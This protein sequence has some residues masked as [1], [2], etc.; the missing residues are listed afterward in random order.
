MGTRGIRVG[1]REIK[2]GMQGIRVGMRR[3]GVETLGMWGMRG[4]RVEMWGIREGMRGIRV[5]VR[6]I[7]VGMR[8]LGVGIRGIRVGMR[9]IEWNTNRKKTK[10]KVYKLQ[11]SFFLK[12]KKKTK[13]DLS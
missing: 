4:I 10:K 2:A 1:T 13:L 12:L 7:R 3:M 11:F 9:E 6:G 5:R 8:G